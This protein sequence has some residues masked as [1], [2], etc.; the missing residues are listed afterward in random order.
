MKPE[1][2]IYRETEATYAS[3]FNVNPRTIT[4]WKQARAPLDDPQAMRTFLATRKHVPASAW[5]TAT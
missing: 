1:N 3:V 4:R 2:K 5:R